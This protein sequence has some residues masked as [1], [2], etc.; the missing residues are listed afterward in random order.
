M[1]RAAFART[2]KSSFVGFQKKSP[3]ASPPHAGTR[4]NLRREAG[5]LLSDGRVLRRRSQRMGAVGQGLLDAL[6]R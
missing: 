3:A 2:E 6:F 4:E 1:G 5:A